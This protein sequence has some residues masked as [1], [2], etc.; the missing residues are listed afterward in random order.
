MFNPEKISAIIEHISK[1]LDV[2]DGYMIACDLEETELVELR[3]HFQV[4]IIDGYG[5][6]EHRYI[7]KKK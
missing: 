4:E 6:F 3:K 2:K 1:R 7:F 5:D